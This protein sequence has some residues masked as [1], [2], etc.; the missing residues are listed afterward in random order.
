MRIIGGHD[1]FDSAMGFGIDK[2]VVLNRSVYADT[3]I[4][5]YKDCGLNYP[6]QE[7]IDLV[8]AERLHSRI[9][10]YETKHHSFSFEPLVVW[11]AGVR[12]GGIMVKIYDNKS[13]APMRREFFWDKDAFATFLK[14]LGVEVKK[15]TGWNGDY[16]FNATNLAD[17]FD[18]KGS[19]AEQEWL[20][21]AGVSIA[22]LN[23]AHA[24]RGGS[25]YEENAG[26]RFDCDG[27]KELGFWKALDAYS[28]FQNLSQWV[29]GVLPRPSAPMI[30]ITDEKTQL[31]KHGMDKWSFKT[32]PGSKK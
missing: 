11:F 13:R 30:D 24:Y 20:I 7:T 31:Q 32:M 3:P 15:D 21:A 10:D 14:E 19:Q 18:N 28:A 12:Y 22:I 23:V 17:H 8:G 9:Y 25:G 1:Y 6:K 4:A 5:R 16:R 29:G 2:T 27:L 26:W